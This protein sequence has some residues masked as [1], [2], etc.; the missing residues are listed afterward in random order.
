[1]DD[2]LGDIRESHYRVPSLRARSDLKDLLFCFR[3][4]E[5]WLPRRFACHRQIH[6]LNL[7]LRQH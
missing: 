3:V 2:Y 7:Q 4:P 5:Q 1:M 6:F